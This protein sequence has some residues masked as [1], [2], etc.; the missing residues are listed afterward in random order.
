MGIPAYVINFD[1]LAEQIKT[2]FQNHISVDITNNSFID[3]TEIQNSLSDIKDVIN[4]VGDKVQNIDYINLIQALNSLGIKLDNLSNTLGI[5]GVQKIYGRNLSIPAV[6]NS[7]DLIF[8]VPSNGKITSITI[9][10]SAW[11]F[12]DNWDLIINDSVVF[13]GVNTKEYGENK[14]FNVYYY[15]ASGSNIVVRF[16]N[17]S[18]SSKVLWV[19]F[20]ILEV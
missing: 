20:N 10:Q 6:N 15:V 17:N 18:A 2:Y 19:D 5:I 16:H 9:S 8:N 14:I 1:E 4:G 3:T 13:S 12:Q 11:N 7:F